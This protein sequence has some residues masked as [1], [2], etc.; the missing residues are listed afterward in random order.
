MASVFVVEHEAGAVR[1]RPA[2]ER[3]LDDETT[4]RPGPAVSV[5]PSASARVRMPAMPVTGA[6]GLRRAASAA[7]AP[8]S[9]T[10]TT[11]RSGA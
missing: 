10:R 5:P 9:A 4:G 7:P 8:S 2:R 3:R 6:G 11:S 1:V